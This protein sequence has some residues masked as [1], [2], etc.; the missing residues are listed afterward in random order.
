MLPLKFN[1]QLLSLFNLA[2]VWLSVSQFVFE[3]EL[4]P[5]S[6]TVNFN[7]ADGLGDSEMCTTYFSIFCLREGR[8]T[9]STNTQ[10][11]PLGSSG[12]LNAYDERLS[13]LQ[14]RRI[15]SPRPWPV[16]AV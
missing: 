7:C 3:F 16:R 10:D 14:T 1:V 12:R 11:C 8:D 9:Q 4:D 13:S 6:V 2:Q 15:I 5:R